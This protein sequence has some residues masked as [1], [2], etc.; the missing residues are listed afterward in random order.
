MLNN[1]PN[2]QV[3]VFDSGVGGLS[4]MREIHERLPQVKIIYASDNAF[5]P[6]GTKAENELI[7]RVEKVIRALLQ[8]QPVDLAVIACNTASTVTLPYLRSYLDIPV[9]G[10]VPAIKPAAQTSRTKVI[11][12]LATPATVARAYTKQL[13]ADFAH[14]C[15]IISV[16]SSRLVEIAEQKLRGESINQAEIT[17]ITREFR[18]T[19]YL[20]TLVLACTHFPL[21]RDEIIQCLPNGI[22]LLDSGEAIARRVEQL[23]LENPFSPRE[24]TNQHLAIFTKETPE[25]HLL[26]STL[27]N[28]S[29]FSQVY[30]NI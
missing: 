15:K 13:I 6:Y 30:L 5:F 21:L 9:V 18:E 11:G 3:L 26:T 28:F 16:G 23:L 1:S 12:L 17:E 22:H 24:I 25:T 4:V 7:A 14:D 10:V 29:I 2:P 8:Y 19:Q 27:K 20:D